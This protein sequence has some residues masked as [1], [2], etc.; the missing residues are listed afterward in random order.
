M[1]NINENTR[2][3]A[4]TLTVTINTQSFR[5]VQNVPSCSYTLAPTSLDESGGGGSA[6]VTL[7]TGQ[8]CFWTASASE[9]WIRVLNTSG[10]GS[11]IINLDLALNPSDVRHAFLTIAGQRVNVTQRRQQ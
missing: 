8:D 4:R 7:T 6:R 11:A 10:V 2:L 5:I 9:G 1:L 3:D